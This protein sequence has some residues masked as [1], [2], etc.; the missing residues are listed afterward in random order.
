[1]SFLKLWEILFSHSLSLAWK[2]L[3]IISL[4]PI[5]VPLTRFY[6]H[7]EREKERGGWGAVVMEKTWVS[8]TS[9][10]PGVGP[11][12]QPRQKG[13]P[14]LLPSPWTHLWPHQ[15][16]TSFKYISLLLFLSR[17]FLSIFLNSST[18]FMLPIFLVEFYSFWF[19][20]VLALGSRLEN[21]RD[22][23]GLQVQV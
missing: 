14:P 3:P 2:L 19:R 20:S 6:H 15:Q 17:N 16:L 23:T 10:E 12:S 22:H 5:R 1:M 21:A 8:W 7:A 13:D 18:Y 4:N 9:P 11:S